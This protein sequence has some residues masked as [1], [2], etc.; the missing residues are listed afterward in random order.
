ML[1]TIAL[2]CRIICL[3]NIQHVHWALAGRESQ[4][5]GFCLSPLKALNVCKYYTMHLSHPCSLVRCELWGLSILGP[6]KS[7]KPA[8]SLEFTR[9][10]FT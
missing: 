3:S 5:W 1:G 10:S 2:H 9:R 4:D 8:F 6:G 7:S